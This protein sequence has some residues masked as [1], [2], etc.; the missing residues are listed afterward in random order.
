MRGTRRA[1]AAAGAAE[2]SRAQ[3]SPPKAMALVPMAAWKNTAAAARLRR[4]SSAA[5]PRRQNTSPLATVTM[6]TLPAIDRS[7]IRVASHWRS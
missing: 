6:T 2:E 3:L 4:P 5:A 7:R 1:T